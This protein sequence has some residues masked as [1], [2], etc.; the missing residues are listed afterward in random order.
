MQK[1]TMHLL[2]KHLYILIIF[3]SGNSN[4]CKLLPKSKIIRNTK[5]FQEDVHCQVLNSQNWQKSSTGRQTYCS[6]WNVIQYLMTKLCTGI[7]TK[8]CGRLLPTEEENIWS[9]TVLFCM[10]YSLLVASTNR[11]WIVSI[12]YS[13]MLGKILCLW[14]NTKIVYGKRVLYH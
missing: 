6:Q 14:Q 5:L 10:V 13:S 12:L 1:T 2:L 3:Y 9:A 4:I 7:T 11:G 8:T